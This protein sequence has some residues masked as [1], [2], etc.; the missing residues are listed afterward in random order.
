MDDLDALVTSAK[1]AALAATTPDRVRSLAAL[2]DGISDPTLREKIANV[3]NGA[4][5]DGPRSERQR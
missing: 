5:P 4:S 2:V 3:I 1:R